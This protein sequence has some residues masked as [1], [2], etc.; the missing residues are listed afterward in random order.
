MSA[1]EFHFRRSGRRPWTIAALIFAAA[2]ASFGLVNDAP[3]WWLL[4]VGFALVALAW[5]V[6]ANPQATLALGASGLSW[7][8]GKNET[9]I[10]LRDIAQ[11]RFTLWA[12]GPDSADVMLHNGEEI[13]IPPACLPPKADFVAALRRR[14]VAVE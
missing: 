13:A 10:A 4:P 9:I 12:D 6:F 5:M 14:D 8:D 1:D 7:S 3:I 2:F 11:V